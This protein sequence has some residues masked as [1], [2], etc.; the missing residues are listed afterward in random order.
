M[1]RSG[2]HL[3]MAFLWVDTRC[4][5]QRPQ[6]CLDC[7]KPACQALLVQIVERKGLHTPEQV[8]WLQWQGSAEQPCEACSWE[9]FV[10]STATSRPQIAA[11]STA[12]GGHIPAAYYS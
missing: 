10:R 9:P 7:G 8:A 2:L 6:A 3:S 5:V 11:I 4:K 12:S 1:C